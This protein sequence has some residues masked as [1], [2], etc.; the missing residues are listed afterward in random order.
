MRF[1]RRG[2]DDVI[3][4]ESRWSRSVAI[5]T[6]A[7]NG[8]FPLGVCH[9]RAPPGQDFALRQTIGPVTVRNAAATTYYMHAQATFGGGVFNFF[10]YLKY[11]RAR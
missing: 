11:R 1:Q 6:V 9:H 10:G 2:R 8:G 4:L 3:G 5:P 7:N